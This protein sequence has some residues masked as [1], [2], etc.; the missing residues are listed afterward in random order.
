MLLR[1]KLLLFSFAS[2]ASGLL[3]LLFNENIILF[4]GYLLQKDLNIHFWEI[5]FE[6]IS[7]ELLVLSINIFLAIKFYV[8]N[9]KRF[10]LLSCLLWI[11]VFIIYVIK[12]T[13]NIPISD[14]YGYFLN[15]LIDYQTTHDLSLI[16]RQEAESRM[17]VIH[18]ISVFLVH[19]NIFNFKIFT[20]ISTSCLIGIVALF[21]RSIMEKQ[22]VLLFFIVVILLF[23]FQYYNSILLP[24]DAL[25]STC[26]VFYVF[27]SLCFLKKNSIWMFALS[28]F[29]ILLAVLNCGSGFAGLIA[30]AWMLLTQKRMKHLFVW[31]VFSIFISVIFFTDYALVHQSIFSS[32]NVL[33]FF[34]RILKCAVFSLAFLGGPFQLPYHIELPFISGAIVWVLFLFLTLKKYYKINPTIYFMLLFLMICSCLPS[35]LRSEYE[36]KYATSIRYGI[37]AMIAFCCCII[38]CFEII[39]FKNCTLSM[40]Y[41]LAFTILYHLSTNLFFYPEVVI[42]KQKLETFIQHIKRD[43]PFEL[44]P[45]TPCT[46][47][48]AKTILK[49]SVQENIY[50]FPE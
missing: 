39:P 6:R 24:T 10:I 37:Y 25:Y 11:L 13:V 42:R 40:K 1:N 17:V 38:G 46:P 49:E 16:F 50:T 33:N 26:T 21:Y 44:P 14:D 31:L 9:S 32:E 8:K 28:L 41:V 47:K 2:L 19:L 7:V 23:Q 35:L 27:S 4:F 22:K 34:N 29:C 15:F 18:L 30:G 45:V 36:I 3:I 12:N 48:E 5:G 43:E 20:F